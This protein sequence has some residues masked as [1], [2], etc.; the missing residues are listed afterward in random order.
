MPGSL[1]IPSLSK[2]IVIWWGVCV[3]AHSRGLGP[4]SLIPLDL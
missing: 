1:H 4:G 2:D 3:F